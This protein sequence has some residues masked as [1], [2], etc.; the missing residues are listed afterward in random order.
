MANTHTSTSRECVHSK[1][2]RRHGR[3]ERERIPKLTERS[4]S[5]LMQRHFFSLVKNEGRIFTHF[6]MV[7]WEEDEEFLH[8]TG[9][10]FC[11]RKLD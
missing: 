7:L 8:E 1:E 10:I 6:E 3:K 11:E 5:S 9:V 4:R 2:G